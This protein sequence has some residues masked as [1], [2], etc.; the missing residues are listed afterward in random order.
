MDRLYALHTYNDEFSYNHCLS[1]DNLLSYCD[2]DVI[3][4]DSNGKLVYIR[5]HM[6][7]DY[8]LILRTWTEE[9][10]IE[11][12]GEGIRIYAFVSGKYLFRLEIIYIKCKR[13]RHVILKCFRKLV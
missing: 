11:V 12:H 9:L 4:S 13:A 3:D 7:F 5:T 8:K 6:R 2:I 10:P 1:T